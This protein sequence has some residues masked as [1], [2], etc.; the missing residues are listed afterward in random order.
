MYLDVFYSFFCICW[1]KS[2]T[3][4]IIPT[5]ARNCGQAENCKHHKPAI[6]CA[7][8]NGS[9]H[10]V[11]SLKNALWRPGWHS[12]LTCKVIFVI[13][14]HLL[15][16]PQPCP[17][18]N[19]DNEL[20]LQP[21]TTENKEINKLKF[22]S[23]QGEYSQNIWLKPSSVRGCWISWSPTA[24][25]L[26]FLV[27]PPMFCTT[28]ILLLITCSYFPYSPSNC[29]KLGKTEPS[30]FGNRWQQGC[31]ISYMPASRN[32]VTPVTEGTATKPWEKVTH[33]DPATELW[34][35]HKGE[36]IWD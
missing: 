11:S 19:R 2:Q 10:G 22:G 7:G 25:T 32:S 5:E 31:G 13:S 4:R 20:Q 8:N 29:C 33:W 24:G 27:I 36:W 35:K 3:Q 18:H 30:K 17:H 26:L 16:H 12:E 9:F 1:R 15:G 21:H 34:G 23:W 28:R 14:L 6:V